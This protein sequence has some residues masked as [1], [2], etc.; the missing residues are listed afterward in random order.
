MQV[1]RLHGARDLRQHEEP[2]P[3]PGAG[4]SLVRVTAVGIC[5]SDIHWFLEGGI[6]ESR[7]TQPLV[8]G[9]ECAGVIAS[10]QRRGERVAI[11]PGIPCGT[12]AFCQEGHPNLCA[13]V[14]FAG[15]EADDG[16]L[17]EY[18]AWP[19]HGLHPLPEALSDADGA[20]LE[21][22]GVALFSVELA[23]LKPG[24]TVGVFGCGPI[25]LL[26]LQVARLAGAA[27]L[28]ATDKLA[29]RREVARSFGATVF[30]A[31]DGR[32]GADVLAATGG[33]GVDVAFEAAGAN[34]AVA[35]AVTAVRPGGKVILVGIPTEDH[36]VF[37]A[38]TARRKGL[39][40][41]LVH[42][43]Q[44]TY[45]RA[46]R[47]VAQGLVDVRSLVTHRFPLAETVQ[48]YALAQRR[49]GLKVIIEP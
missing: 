23:H 41:K 32:E 2:V 22:L 18:I 33:Q 16:A 42:R 46:I 40:L 4:E 9:H 19:T 24:M 36:T 27:R 43:M 31:S 5:G 10:G 48:A 25:G 44:H 39:T 30:P 21:P 11:D 37:N 49:E 38:H 45:P 6:G 14:Y 13:H 34:E 1:F 26:V 12:C 47:L 29:H 7:V 3:V 28:I 20:M 17:R 15:C 8:L 35:A